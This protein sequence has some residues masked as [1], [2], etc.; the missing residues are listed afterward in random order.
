MG[1]IMGLRAKTLVHAQ[2]STPAHR[3]VNNGIGGALEG[4]GGQYGNVQRGGQ[5]GIKGVSNT[6]FF[7]SV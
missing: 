6:L 5:E 7:F 2:V 4:G 1:R 3:G